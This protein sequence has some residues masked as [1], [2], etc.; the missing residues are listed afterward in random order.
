MRLD[1]I[2]AHGLTSCDGAQIDEASLASTRVATVVFQHD[3]EVHPL[4]NSCGDIILCRICSRN[5]TSNLEQEVPPTN[6]EER[7]REAISTL[8]PRI[9]VRLPVFAA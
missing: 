1:K 4:R 8:P 6:S 7:A 5:V 2:D 3:I 9:D